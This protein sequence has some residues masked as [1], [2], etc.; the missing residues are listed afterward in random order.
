[1]AKPRRYWNKNICL[2]Y[3][4]Y[5]RYYTKSSFIFMKMPV[6]QFKFEYL[7]TIFLF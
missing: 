6:L 1:M 5:R 7:I 2:R 4:N 3:C